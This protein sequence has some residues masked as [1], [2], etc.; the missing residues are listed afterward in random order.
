MYL[1][2]EEERILSENIGPRKRANGSVYYPEEYVTLIIKKADQALETYHSGANNG[3]DGAREALYLAARIAQT[4]AP[5]LK[6]PINDICMALRDLD[7]GQQLEILTKSKTMVRP[8][9]PTTASATK[10]LIA[11]VVEL[12]YREKNDLNASLQLVLNFVKDW[13][14]QKTTRSITLTT[15]KGWRKEAQE[16]NKEDTLPKAYSYFLKECTKLYGGT[17]H[18]L[19]SKIKG[20]LSCTS[21][22]KSIELKK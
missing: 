14:I 20:M 5:K 17:P 1:T 6:K 10:G 4:I 18:E 3:R 22:A 21:Y 13:K 8:K 16:G 19:D 15:L 9:A 12:H 7:Q 11:A 2:P